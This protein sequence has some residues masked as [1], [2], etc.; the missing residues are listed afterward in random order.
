MY[1]HK[2]TGKAAAARSWAGAGEHKTRTKQA[3][4]ASSRTNGPFALFCG[5]SA[6][7]SMTSLPAPT[8]AAAA[9]EPILA[10]PR[11]VPIHIEA[12]TKPECVVPPTEV[13]AHV[14]SYLSTHVHV[15]RP[16]PLEGFA[17]HDALLGQTLESLVVA[18]MGGEQAVSAWRAEM[19]VHVYAYAEDQPAGGV[20]FV[21]S[22]GE[23]GAPTAFSAHVCPCRE[24]AGLWESIYVSPATKEVL[25]AMSA[26]ALLF[27]MKGVDPHLVSGNR[28][29]L[30]HGQPGTGKSTL[31]RGLAQKVSDNAFFC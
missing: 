10:G 2:A 21:L 15:F 20:D 30:L 1:T 3:G 5:V 12:R 19:L 14:A 28:L 26:T 31:A 17:A 8:A 16:G 6:A 24:L 23:E 11:R 22:E 13:Q 7:I 4:G 9:T 29:I 18:E 27:S 25:L